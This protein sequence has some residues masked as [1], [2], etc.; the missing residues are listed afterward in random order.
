MLTSVKVVSLISFVYKIAFKDCAVATMIA[1]GS[2]SLYCLR[3]IMV[4]LLILLSI[5]TTVRFYK[6]PRI[7]AYS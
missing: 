6:K 7:L 3:S 1:S 5:L 2:L 4:K